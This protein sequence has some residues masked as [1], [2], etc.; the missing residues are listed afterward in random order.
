MISRK[1]SLLIILASLAYVGFGQSTDEPRNEP[2]KGRPD[3]PGTFLVD[4]GFNIPFGKN[5]NFN[6]N[7][8]GSRTL[9]LYYQG[10]KRLGSSKLSVLPGIGLG[11]ERYR[12]SND[13][14]LQYKAGPGGLFDSLIFVPAESR[15]IEPNR[16]NKSQLIM[17]NLDILLDLRF[18]ANPN[19]PNRSLKVSVGLKG[20][21]VYDSFTKIKYRENSETKK[22]KDKQD[23][24]LNQFRYGVTFRVGIGNF[25]AFA[26]YN[27]SPIFQVD[28]A[29]K[30]TE[31]NTF[32]TGI[33]LAAF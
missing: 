30:G 10:E 27:L 25:N 4:F 29:P 18:T 21:F 20:G 16:I 24:N 2:R 7:F 5:G 32:T 13:A 31:L 33:S 3:I 19:D 12:F 23:W 9:N 17:N 26:Y 15:F 14:T 6:T 22:I 1:L 8:W 11:L 28:G